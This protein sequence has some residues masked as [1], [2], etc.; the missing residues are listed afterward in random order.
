MS[1]LE[2]SPNDRNDIT[3]QEGYIL[4]N[5]YLIMAPNPAEWGQKSTYTNDYGLRPS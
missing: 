2:A 4:E 5:N 1:Y 3:V